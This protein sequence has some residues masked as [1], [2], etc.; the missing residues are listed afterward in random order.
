MTE[1]ADFV[2]K[3]YMQ[4]VEAIKETMVSRDIES[5]RAAL[6]KVNMDLWFLG[7]HEGSVRQSS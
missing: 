7:V 5:R 2:F 1:M 3:M 4:K 6:A